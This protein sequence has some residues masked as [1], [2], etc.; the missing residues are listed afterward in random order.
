MW[1]PSSRRSSLAL[2][3][4]SPPPPPLP[5]APLPP[6]TVITSFTPTVGNTC[7]YQIGQH[8]YQLTVKPITPPAP[9]NPYTIIEQFNTNPIYPTSREVKFFDASAISNGELPAG[10][11]PSFYFE[12]GAAG[13]GMWRRLG[14]AA[15]SQ[16]VNGF[17]SE[18]D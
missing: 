6:I 16:S 10:S 3:R 2:H 9:Q 17:F 13:S 7:Q 14:S 1:R 18:E 15:S 12:V 8:T 5:P 11:N 4:P